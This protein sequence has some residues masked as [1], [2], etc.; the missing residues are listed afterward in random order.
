MLK[1]AYSDDAMSQHMVHHWHKM[2]RE[3]KQNS[4]NEGYSGRPLTFQSNQN[5]KKLRD[6]LDSDR[7]L[8]GHEQSFLLESPEKISKEGETR[9]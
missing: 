7:R 6:M 2:F 5:M 4:K 9:K 3:N 1:Q 8:S